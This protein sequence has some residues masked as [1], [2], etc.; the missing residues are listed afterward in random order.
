MR[1][2]LPLLALLCAA[3]ACGRRTHDVPD[4]F[5]WEEEVAPGTTIHLRTL[6]GGI[7]VT[8]AAGRS[9]RVAGSTHWVGRQDPVHFAWTREGSDIY[10]CALWT[11]RADCTEDSDGFARSG[12][13]WLDM[14]SLFKRRPTNVVASLRLALPV[15]VKV[16]ARATNGTITLHGATAGITAHALNGSI[17]IANSSGPVEAKGTN[18]NISV[19][20]D[21]LKPD[22]HVLLETVNGNMTASLPSSLDGDVEL[23]TVNGRVRS[24]FP[25][26]IYGD[27]SRHKLHGQIGKSSR[28]VLLRTVNGNVS[29]LKQPTMPP[30]EAAPAASVPRA[31]S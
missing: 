6:S 8:P 29:L 12:H 26:R 22:D 11:K 17:N 2:L 20:L 24:D 3:T 10:V 5:R 30:S 7:E 25:I 13:S 1:W 27:E 19:A 14:F 15:G 21:S 23:S 16:D 9:A 4:A 31:R 28:E 18:A